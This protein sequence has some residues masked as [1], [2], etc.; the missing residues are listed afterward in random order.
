LQNIL[1]L[2]AGDYEY[3]L[4]P[5]A[6]I[7]N[8]ALMDFVGDHDEYI[9]RFNVVTVDWAECSSFIPV[10]GFIISLNYW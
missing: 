4:K 9:A 5:I 7:A 6:T 3:A 8:G 2:L 10:P 1:S